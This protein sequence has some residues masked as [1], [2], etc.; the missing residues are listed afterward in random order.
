M[1]L[2]DEFSFIGPIIHYMVVLD[3]HIRSN[4]GMNASVWKL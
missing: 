2:T 4:N 1:S 3:K